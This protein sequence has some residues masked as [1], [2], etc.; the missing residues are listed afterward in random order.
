MKII[1]YFIQDLFKYLL[2]FE[3]FVISFL[4]EI[5]VMVTAIISCF[6]RPVVEE[7]KFVK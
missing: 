5:F 7:S 1:R 6:L 2:C 4:F 3:C